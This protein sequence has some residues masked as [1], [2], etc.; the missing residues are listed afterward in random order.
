M[1]AGMTLLVQDF[2][3]KDESNGQPHE[4]IMESFPGNLPLALNVI[5]RQKPIIS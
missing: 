5:E 4:A 3:T 1:I 2:E